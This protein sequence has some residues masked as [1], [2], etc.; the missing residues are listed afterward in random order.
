MEE[1]VF[2]LTPL[3]PVHIGTG[4]VMGP[5]EYFIDPPNKRL[6]RFNWH[7]VVAAW[8]DS[9][10]RRFEQLVQ[11]AVRA[12]QMEQARK[13]LRGAALQNAACHLYATRIGGPAFSGL[14]NADP[15]RRGEIRL[16]CRNLHTRQAVIPGSSVKGAIRTAIVNAGA[17][18][19]IQRLHQELHRLLMADPSERNCAWVQLEEIAL[20]RKRNETE[21]DPLRVLLVSDGAMGEDAV[22][23]DRVVIRKRTGSQSA[24]SQ[25][26][27]YV[28]R[29]LSRAD[30]RDAPSCLISIAIATGRAQHPRSPLRRGAIGWD[31]LLDACNAFYY[32]RYLEEVQTFSFLAGT[33]W[34]PDALPEG[35]FL[36][37]LGRFSH[38]ESLSVDALRSDW[39]ARRNRPSERVGGSRSLCACDEKTL[40]PFG[41][42]LLEPA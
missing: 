23:V 15:L 9:D 1:R 42:V 13:M 6:V 4:E 2:R 33:Q 41:W 40:A 10:R 34:V 21:K 29:L 32:R 35:A 8:P 3:T 14:H 31:F 5:E 12:E 17:A 26:L 20:A 18:A 38:F 24:G 11:T 28:E 37:R 22:R 7:A 25:I 30:R 27:Q 36:L 39:D 16:L 19:E